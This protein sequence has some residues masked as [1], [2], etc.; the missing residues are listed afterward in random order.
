MNPE[1]LY[2]NHI[3]LKLNLAHLSVVRI[4]DPG[5]GKAHMLMDAPSRVR[6]HDILDQF[7]FFSVG[8][9]RTS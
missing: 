1:K 5:A 2:M 6:K 9:K 3:P 7:Q 4:S 8:Q